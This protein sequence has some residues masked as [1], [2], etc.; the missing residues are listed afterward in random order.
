MRP[1]WSETLYLVAELLA[2][3]APLVIG[4]NMMDVAKQEGFEVK[5]DVLASAIGVR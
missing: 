3:P 1:R 4:L 2:L 5:P